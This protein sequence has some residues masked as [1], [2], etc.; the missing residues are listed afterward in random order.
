MNSLQ[1]EYFLAVSECGNITSAAERYYISQPAMSRVI[2]S[3]EDELQMK[4]FERGIRGVELTREGHRMQEAFLAA[5]TSVMKGLEDIRTGALNKVGSVKIGML[6]GLD[7]YL[8]LYEHLNRINQIYPDISISLESEDFYD[9]RE[10]LKSGEIDLAVTI[11]AALTDRFNLDTVFLAESPRVLIYSKHLPITINNPEINPRTFMKTPFYAVSVNNPMAMTLVNQYCEPYGFVP[12][13]R[14]V[15]SVESL[16]TMVQNLKGVA[17][18]DSFSRELANPMIGSLE[19]SS[20]E[21]LVIAWNK[22]NSNPILSLVLSFFS[23]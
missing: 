18:V 10:K 13:I 21:N 17:I 23:K 19:L 12:E 6:N 5:K 3:L 4:L 8:L 9:L 11:E 1:I 16:M 15:R 22:G 20:K 14:S 7:S 2:R